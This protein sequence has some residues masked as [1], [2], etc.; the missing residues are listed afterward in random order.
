MAGSLLAYLQVRYPH[1]P[2]RHASMQSFIGIGMIA[3]GL[4]LVRPESAFPGF[5]AFLPVGGAV[6]LIASGAQGW[7]NRYVLATRPMVWCGLISYPLYLWHWVAIGYSNILFVGKSP[8]R[9]ACCVLVSVVLAALTYLLIERPLRNN[10]LGKAYPFVLL[11]CMIGVLAIALA[12][13]TQVLRPRL[14]HFDVPEQ[15]EWTFLQSINGNVGANVEAVYSLGG[16][17]ATS[18]LFIGDSHIAQY[19]VRLNR[20]LVADPARPDATLAIGGGCIPLID[21]KTDDPMRKGCWPLRDQAYRMAGEQRFQR[22]VIGGA[23]NKYMLT[24]GYYFDDGH[25]RLP[26]NSAQ[27]RKAALREMAQQVEAWQ[28]AGKEVVFILDNPVSTL[29]SSTGWRTRFSLSQDHFPANSV[30]QVP[31]EQVSLRADLMA[32]ALGEKMT[33]VDPFSAVCAG[34]SCRMTSESGK[35]IFKDS[36]HFNPEWSI[37]HATFIDVTVS[38]TSHGKSR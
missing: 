6:L 27:G 33:V 13:M 32:W 11:A 15:N 24:D 8:V 23:W 12:A 34:T 35:P 14:R 21:V 17:R 36:S 30:I 3:A 38:P 4:A 9:A 22:V 29:L 37:D 5:W 16:K 31:A 2:V 7:I 20:L 25:G 18:V 1:S 19:A 10:R 26:L 28:R